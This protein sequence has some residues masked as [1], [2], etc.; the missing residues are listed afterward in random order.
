ML[1]TK[2]YSH[3]DFA[4]WNCAIVKG[5]LV[6]WDWEEAGAYVEGRDERHFMHQVQTL[7][8]RGGRR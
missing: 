8:M 2:G 3:G 4:P 5:R 6:V 7:L 1:K